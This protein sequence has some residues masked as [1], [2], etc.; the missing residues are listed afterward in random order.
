MF[1]NGLFRKFS[2]YTA[3]GYYSDNRQH[4]PEYRVSLLHTKE[5]SH[6]PKKQQTEVHSQQKRRHNTIKKDR[7]DSLIYPI[8]TDFPCGY[9]HM[10]GINNYSLSSP[11]I[12]F[13]LPSASYSSSQ[14][15]KLR[16]W[17]LPPDGALS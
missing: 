2:L 4:S 15:F 13:I 12:V 14:T 8:F 5:T 3:H 7:A 17:F 11:S 6:T 10:D 1:K 16:K 9:S